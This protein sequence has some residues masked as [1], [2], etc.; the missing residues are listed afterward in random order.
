[1]NVSRSIPLLET[2]RALVAVFVGTAC[3]CSALLFPLAPAAATAIRFPDEVYPYNVLEQDVAVV[4]REFGQNLG[5]RVKL[6][7][8]ATGTVKGKLPRLP[9]L[10]FLNHIC[11]TYGLEWYY[12]GA[13]LHV[14]AVSEEVTRFL[15]LDKSESPR[16]LIDSLK[17]LSFYDERYPLRTGPDNASVVVLGPPVYVSLVEQ[18]LLSMQGG[19]PTQTTVYR[20]GAVSVEK[21]GQVAK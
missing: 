19:V 10:G 16:P 6:S 9:A 13:T 11:R 5:V 20:G 8:K 14:S 1:M 3:G 21:F 12:D 2:I 4:L 15:P 7:P 17:Q 18:T